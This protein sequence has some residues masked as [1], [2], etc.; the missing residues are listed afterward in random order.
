MRVRQRDNSLKGLHNT[1]QFD[2]LT[3]SKDFDKHFFESYC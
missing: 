1:N 2:V 3:R